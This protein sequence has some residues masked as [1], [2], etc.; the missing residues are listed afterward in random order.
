M[1]GGLSD[2]PYGHYSRTPSA[3]PRGAAPGHARRAARSIKGN[4]QNRHVVDDPLEGKVD[5]SRA[6]PHAKSSSERSRKPRALLAKRSIPNSV[7]FRRASVT[8]SET[9]MRVA[10]A[11]TTM[12]S[13]G[14][15]LRVIREDADDRTRRLE[16]YRIAVRLEQVRR[17]ARK[18]DARERIAAFE[19]IAFSRSG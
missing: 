10:P 6:M 5:A 2:S 12:R 9:A 1:K 4:G 14:V 17:V 15:H 16:R 18:K 3:D 19:R 11:R 8:P 13:S 7:P